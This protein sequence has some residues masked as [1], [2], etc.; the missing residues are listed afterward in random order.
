MRFCHMI[1]YKKYKI[2]FHHTEKKD[3][4]DMFINM[5]SKKM[6]TFAAL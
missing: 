4:T 3:L 2:I 1:F 5:K 6:I